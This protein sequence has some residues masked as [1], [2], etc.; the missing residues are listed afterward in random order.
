V[1]RALEDVVGARIVTAIDQPG[2]FSPGM[3]ARTQLSDG[4]RVFIKA[5]ST[6]PNPESPELHRREAVIAARLPAA[7]PVPR[8]LGNFD[9]GEWVAL[10]F[11]DIDGAQPE[12]PWR[13]NELERVLDALSDLS[14]SLTP[15]PV[16]TDAMSEDWFPFIGW[17]ELM[18]KPEVE[19]EPWARSNIAHLAELESGWMEAARGETLLHADLRADNILLGQ[20]RVV[21]IDWPHACVGAAWV[22]LLFFLPSVAMQGGPE[23]WTI[24][25]RHPVS[26]GAP[27][28]DVDAVLAA[29]SGYFVWKGT[30]PPPP[31]LPTL[32]EFQ[33]AQGVAALAWLRQRLDPQNMQI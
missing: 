20:N 24:F 5:I 28:E 3:A 22:D 9:D 8:L 10:V 30:L 14:A 29:V 7:A 18:T 32:R 25:D 4:Q 1:R 23:P 15:S 27:R 12:L 31:G 13:S 2:G 6:T 19:I 17:R 11:E 21:F 26:A 33:R 16:E